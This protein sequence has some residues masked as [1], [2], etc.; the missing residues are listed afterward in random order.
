MIGENGAKS[1]GESFAHLPTTLHTFH[2]YLS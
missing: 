1:L 2:L